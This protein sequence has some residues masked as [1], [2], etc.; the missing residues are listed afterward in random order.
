[1][2]PPPAIVTTVTL[3]CDVSVAVTVFGLVEVPLA[4]ME[5]VAGVAEVTPKFNGVVVLLTAG[6]PAASTVST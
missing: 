1:V 6:F 5:I 3:L 4:G 2:Y